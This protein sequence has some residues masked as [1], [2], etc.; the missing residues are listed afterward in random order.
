MYLFDIMEKLKR[1]KE[2]NQMS[3]FFSVVLISSQKDEE[4]MSAESVDNFLPF[5]DAYSELNE[6]DDEKFFIENL[7]K[8]DGISGTEDGGFVV[9]D[10]NL[11]F[12]KNYEEF[13]NV[14]EEMKKVSLEEFSSKN[15]IEYM[16][17]RRKFK[18]TMDES[19]DL[20]LF[21]NEALSLPDLIR[22]LD[23]GKTYYAIAQYDVE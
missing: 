6:N 8:S 5:H 4:V 20:F 9:N 15:L 18:F 23:E 7:I 16:D 3:M 17:L 14:L 1:A 22:T 11:Y 19:R 21:D 2:E 13:L 12:K 10:K